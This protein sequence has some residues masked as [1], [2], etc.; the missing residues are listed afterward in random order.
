MNLKLLLLKYMT[1]WLQNN[2]LSFNFLNALVDT[3]NYKNK[4]DLFIPR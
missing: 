3:M 4:R 1:G 2:F